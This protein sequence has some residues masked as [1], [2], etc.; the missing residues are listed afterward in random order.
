MQANDGGQQW[1]K[2]GD[3][4][5][6][7]RCGATTYYPLPLCIDCAEDGIYET[8]KECTPEEWSR[9]KGQRLKLPEGSRR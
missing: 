9:G 3:R 1:A 4:V 2:R 5:A 8:G 7:L 6:C